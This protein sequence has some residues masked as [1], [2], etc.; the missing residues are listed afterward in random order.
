MAATLR[1]SLT[2]QKMSAHVNVQLKSRLESW[3]YSSV[4]EHSTA[5]REVTGSNPGAPSKTLVLPAIFFAFV[6]SP[7]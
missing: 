6:F 5:D 4:V 3:G 1:E 2:A 7:F